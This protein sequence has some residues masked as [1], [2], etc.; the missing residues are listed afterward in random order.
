MLSAAIEAHGHTGG[1]LGCPALAS[2][3]NAIKPQS[4]GWRERIR[5]IIERTLTG[6]ARNGCI[7]R[8]RVAETQR[9]K[10]R[11]EKA[12]DRKKTRAERCAKDV[13][14]G[15]AGNGEHIAGRHAV[16]S[17]ENQR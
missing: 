3:G 16:A 15:V 12:G 2:H 9:V 6:M 8:E 5:A 1:G 14:M 10:Y 4:K 7:R 17:G 13:P 11:K